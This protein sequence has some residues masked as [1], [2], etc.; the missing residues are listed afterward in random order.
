MG[1][2]TETASKTQDA[3]ATISH[4]NVV[5]ALLTVEANG[6]TRA[7]RTRHQATKVANA[8]TRHV[9]TIDMLEHVSRL[10]TSCTGKEW[11]SYVQGKTA[12]QENENRYLTP[13]LRC[14][15]AWG[16]H[17]TW[18]LD[19]P[20]PAVFS[21]TSLTTTSRPAGPIC[22]AKRIPTCAARTRTTSHCTRVVGCGQS[23]QEFGGAFTALEREKQIAGGVRLRMRLN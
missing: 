6:H 14:H 7:Q 21:Y 11:E 5:R 23:R 16:L 2:D 17:S 22:S 1:Q 3:P 9:V 20:A 15:H 18:C 19:L 8:P 12:D 4:T 13:A 10:H